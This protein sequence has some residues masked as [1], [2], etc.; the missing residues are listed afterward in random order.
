MAHKQQAL[1]GAELLQRFRI[2]LETSSSQNL[3]IVADTRGFGR[4]QKKKKIKSGRGILYDYSVVQQKFWALK[5]RQKRDPFS[6]PPFSSVHKHI[7]EKFLQLH[8]TGIIKQFSHAAKPE[9]TET[10]SLLALKFESS[11]DSAK[12]LRQTIP[13]FSKQNARIMKKAANRFM[14]SSVTF[15]KSIN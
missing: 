12:I 13:W 11:L 7:Q 9:I 15:T 3:G 8:K 10:F 6:P 5:L 2:A 1:P 14:N 4:N